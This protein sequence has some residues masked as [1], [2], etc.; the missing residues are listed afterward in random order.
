M[1]V[2]IVVSTYGEQRWA[3]LAEDRAIPST[4]GQGAHEVI[5]THDPNGTVALARNAGAARATGDWLVFLD[6]DDELADGYVAAMLA[7]TAEVTNPEAHLFTP[8]VSY[9]EASGRRQPPKFWPVVPYQ[10][11]NWMVVG[12][13]IYREMFKALGGFRNYGDPPGSNA[14]EDWGLWAL[15]QR[16]GCSVVKV[17]DA[18]YVAWVGSGSRHR[19]ADHET[20]VRWH[21]EIGRD[22]FPERYPEGWVD[23]YGRGG[24][25]R[26]TA[27]GRR[28]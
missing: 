17:P 11:A 15:A 19:G 24:R 10:D 4:A 21:Y 8:A 27:R 1:R 28:G 6:A 20:R 16:E 7:A 12:T 13:M 9:V 14:Y 25:R 23:Q 3:Q 22:L 5:F 18:V 26:A 2:S